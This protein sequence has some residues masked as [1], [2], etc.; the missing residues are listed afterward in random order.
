[1]GI[2]RKSH[3]VKALNFDPKGV[4]IDAPCDPDPE[5]P[6]APNWVNLIHSIGH[7][8]GI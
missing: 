7:G 5:D 4:K 6:P 2:V 3:K 1:M 8:H